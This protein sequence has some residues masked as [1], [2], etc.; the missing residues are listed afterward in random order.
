MQRG[1]ERFVDQS[2]G[3]STDI[4]YSQKIYD[5]LEAGSQISIRFRPVG[6]IPNNEDLLDFADYIFFEK[7]LSEEFGKLSYQR[8][9]TG[10]T[11]D[12]PK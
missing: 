10:F 4:S 11:W 7:P 5:F 6:H 2:T 12:I 1:N 8:E 9:K 3:C